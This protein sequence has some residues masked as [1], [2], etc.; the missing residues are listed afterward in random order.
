MAQLIIKKQFTIVFELLK[1]R[2]SKL[3]NCTNFLVSHTFSCTPQYIHTFLAKKLSP[4]Y[5]QYFSVA[6]PIPSICQYGHQFFQFAKNR[7]IPFA[8]W[9]FF[10]KNLNFLKTSRYKT[11]HMLSSTK[12]QI[13]CLSKLISNLYKLARNNK[14]KSLVFPEAFPEYL[15]NYSLRVYPNI[16]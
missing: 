10:D 3:Q 9:L 13:I 14:T 7:S 16:P 11:L 6:G 8:C 12:I 2:R 1:R 15:L 5:L 4:V